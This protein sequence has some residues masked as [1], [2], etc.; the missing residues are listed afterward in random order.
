MSDLVSNIHIILQETG[1]ETWDASATDIQ[2]VAFE[3]NSVMGF[4]CVLETAQAIIQQWPIAEADL[5]AKYAPKLRL[6][7]D[8]AWNVY[9]AFLTSARASDVE[10]G[11]IRL[12]EENL[13]RT[14][15][16]TATSL[17]TRDDVTKALLPLLPIVSKPVLTNEDP[18]QRLRRRISA[19]APSVVDA[20]L[21]KS[22]SAKDFVRLLGRTP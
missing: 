15:K 21:D 9:C 6:A 11:R 22:I 7:G 8:K 16:I 13:E 2:V 17:I 3:D 12:I 18:D 1:Y 10:R 19:I 5:L 20:A 4:V 14:R